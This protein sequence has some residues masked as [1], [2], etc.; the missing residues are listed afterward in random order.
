MEL[1]RIRACIAVGDAGGFRRAAAELG[2]AQPALSRQIRGLEEE[3]GARLFDRGSS[4]VRLT[5]AGRRF[6][7]RARHLVGEYDAICREA[8]ALDRGDSGVLRIGVTPDAT[9]GD[10]VP[11][12]LGALAREMPDLDVDLREGAAV[13]LAQSVASGAL[14]GAFLWSDVGQA[15]DLASFPVAECGLCLALPEGSP[16]AE[17]EAIGPSDLAGETLIALHQ[18]AAPALHGA[19]T[20]GISESRLRPKRV[21]TAQNEAEILAMVR[22]GRGMGLVSAWND[23]RC[24]NGIVLREIAGAD[25]QMRLQFAVQER[26]TSAPLRRLIEMISRNARFQGSAPSKICQT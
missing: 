8:R 15:Y 23:Q 11:G 10:V 3:I 24:P 5:D 7:D 18:A 17:R 19:L 20:A 2:L 1:K 9:W 26:E 6:L 4:G 21:H 16:L 12:L 14:D 13:E 22:M 25:L